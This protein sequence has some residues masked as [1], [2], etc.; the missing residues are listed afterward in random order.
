MKQK[1]WG[2]QD[3]SVMHPNPSGGG[4]TSNTQLVDAYCSNSKQKNHSK[5][6]DSVTSNSS[7]HN[8]QVSIAK[9]IAI[10]LMVIGHSGC[11]EVLGRFIYY[12]HMPLFFF[13]SGFLF[14][15]Y[16]LVN[17][18]EFIWKRFK[19]LLIP[20]FKWSVIFLVLH[21]VFYAWH[22]YDESYSYSEFGYQLKQI[23]T[24][25]GTEQLLGGYWFLIESFLS[26]IIAL[27]LLH[28]GLNTF[29]RSS[30]SKNRTLLI[31]GI[32]MLFSV[33]ACMIYLKSGIDIPK[34]HGITLLAVAFFTAGLFYSKLRIRANWPIGLIGFGILLILATFT[35][36]QLS[37]DLLDGWRT[38]LFFCTGL[39]GSIATFH[40][41]GIFR[42]V[43]ERLFDYLGKNTLYILT[44]HFSGFKLAGMLKC[45]IF[46]MPIE[47]IS[48]F[49][50]IAENNEFF[51]PI[52]VLIG[53]AFSIGMI[54]IY[55]ISKRKLKIFNLIRMKS[56]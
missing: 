50:V 26:C 38:P 18:K 46:D 25:C 54:E 11:P 52:S 44:F 23:F 53:I 37:S 17:K 27:L 7:P 34:I 36:I 20:F 33:A 49:P 45:G 16:Y 21:N 28:L 2:N 29:K 3:L 43:G 48:Q 24:L 5:S 56:F 13:V 32:I 1:E 35:D 22:F 10:L 39:V 55:G 12:F 51:W 14:K 6:N 47:S 4:Y 40:I 42:S 19:G 31:I 41:S 30:Q 8:K 15:D 9:G